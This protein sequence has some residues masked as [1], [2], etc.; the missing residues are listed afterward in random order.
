MSDKD[1]QKI[2]LQLKTLKAENEKLKEENAY[3]KF[4]LEESQSKRYK[5]KKN[6]FSKILS[7]PKK[8]RPPL[9]RQRSSALVYTPA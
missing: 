4:R 3:L 1:I 9:P 6:P 7:P 2:L 8:D 5:S